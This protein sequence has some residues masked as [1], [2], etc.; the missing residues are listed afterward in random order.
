MAPWQRL[1]RFLAPGL[2]RLLLRLADPQA[3][4]QLAFL[5]VVSGVVAGAV[6]VFFRLL[7]DTPHPALFGIENADD[8]EHLPWFLRLFLPLAGALLLGWWFQRLSESVR[9]VGVYHVIECIG[10]RDGHLPL[11]NAGVQLFSAAL[12]I[13]S[14]Y[15]VGREGPSIH[16][17]AACASWM[18]QKLGLPNNGIRVLVG[19]GCAGAIAAAFNTPLAGVIF[20]M[21][22]IMAEYSL[23]SFIPIILAAVCATA[24]SRGVFGSDP[25]FVV[26]DISF[27]SLTE[28]FYIMAMGI[29]IGVMASVFIRM[30]GMISK[31]SS[32]YPIWQPIMLAGLATGLIGLLVPEIMGIGYDTVNRAFLGEL[33]LAVMVSVL[34]CK[35]IAT[36]I[37]LGAGVPGGVIGPSLV[38]GALAGGATGLVLTDYIG[39][40]VSP[41]FYAM[42]G[43]GAMM[44]ATLNAPLAAL[45][46]L[47]ELTANSHVILPGMLAIVA[48]GLTCQQLL[49]TPSVFAYLLHLKGV[50]DPRLDPVSQF[51]RR[52]GI[53][54]S[55]DRRVQQI[56]SAIKYETL[57]EVLA[58]PPTWLLLRDARP[59]PQIIFTAELIAA[60]G[61]KPPGEPFDLLQVSALR[62]DVAP[63]TAQATLFGALRK[64]NNSQVDALYVISPHSGRVLG[65]ITRQDIERSYRYPGS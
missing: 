51:L 47:L 61:T 10:H 55:M 4:W 46:A 29:V 50:A 13:A 32:A 22:V 27:G 9:Q 57:Q 38:I 19:A 11:A 17:G 49:D 63:I 26:P 2:E 21:E 28:L 24:V 7:I 12:A 16:I 15:S 34:C 37:A 3:L 42:L 8:Y 5:G 56:A 36:V 41:A 6:M 31:F 1:Q 23:I 64:M 53:A 44:G 60:L 58:T 18:G 14:G 45:T 25:V 54:M 40:E 52:I 30:L 65:I 43:M 20:T 35:M 33:G 48:A 39:L 62:M 59:R